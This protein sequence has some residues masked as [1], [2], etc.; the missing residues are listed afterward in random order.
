MTAQAQKDQLHFNIQHVAD[1]SNSRRAGMQMAIGMGFAHADATKVAVVI[2]ELARNILIYAKT[3]AII[4]KEHKAL[5]GKVGIKIIADDSGPGIAVLERAMTD[6]FTTSGGLG[7]G[8]SGS[9]RLMD[10]FYIHSEVG[11]GTNI[12]AVK[13]LKK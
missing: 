2:S 7:L 5:D 10:E 12:T 6:G 4:V 9:K 13:W 11:K 8:L 3:G 1:V